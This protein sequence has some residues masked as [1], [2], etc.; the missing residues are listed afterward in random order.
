MTRTLK[1]LL[2]AIALLAGMAGGAEAQ[3]TKTFPIAGNVALWGSWSAAASDGLG[4]T[5]TGMNS[6]ESAFSVNFVGT[7]ASFN[8]FM[9]TGSQ[10]YYNTW[11]VSVDGGAPVISGAGNNS[12]GQYVNCVFCSGLTDGPHKITVEPYWYEY[13][14][15]SHW[16]LD[17]TNTVTITGANPSIGALP[18]RQASDFEKT[19]TVSR[20]V[21][22]GDSRTQSFGS[23]GTW[24]TVYPQ[25]DN[26]YT[27]SGYPVDL[28]TLIN[29]SGVFVVNQGTFGQ[30]ASTMLSREAKDVL[31]QFGA[32]PVAGDTLVYWGGFNDIANNG[33][34][35]AQ[36]EAIT[37]QYVQAAR[38]YGVKHILVG[39][40][41]AYNDNPVMDTYNAWLK[42][43]FQSIGATACP[44][45]AATLVQ[46][47]YQSDQTHFN[48]GGNQKIAQAVYN[49][50][51]AQVV[52]SAGTVPALTLTLSEAISS[53]AVVIT[54]AP[55]GGTSPYT[56]TL[57]RS[58]TAGG[59]L[60]QILS[61]TTGTLTDPSPLPGRTQLLQR[62]GN[63]QQQPTGHKDAHA[64]RRA[65]RAVYLRPQTHPPRE[66]A[67][68][69]HQLA[70]SH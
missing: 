58:A 16:S 31:T 17:V 8:I 57:S 6:E 37:T 23:S 14:N 51:Q 3:T 25:H 61:N 55:T 64:G 59:S 53:G 39:T 7:G 5:V 48:D 68:S 21:D 47:D 22:D 26:G 44:D 4:H 38:T 9:Y 34:T 62:H 28:A 12:D 30:F 43:N 65:N 40:L 35:A 63:R 10:T 29:N 46:S 27:P 13:T 24:G 60:S 11:W 67:H 49:S 36:M 33:T 41:P 19:T 15:N 42:T 54:A 50:M 56:Y 70:R 66:L 1:T 18:T 45:L 69:P 20:V 32:V 2:L 52:Q